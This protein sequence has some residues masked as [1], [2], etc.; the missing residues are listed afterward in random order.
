MVVLFVL[1]GNILLSQ[2]VEYQPLES[3]FWLSLL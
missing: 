1:V 3:Q 2:G